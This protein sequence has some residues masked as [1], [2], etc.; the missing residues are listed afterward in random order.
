[1]PPIKLQKIN[2]HFKTAFFRKQPTRIYL[3]I[4]IILYYLYR[5]VEYTLYI[6]KYAA[7]IYI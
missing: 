6:Y 1:M 2:N 4:G 3:I 7:I 5:S